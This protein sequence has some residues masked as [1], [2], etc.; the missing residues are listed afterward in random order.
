ME[1]QSPLERGFFREAEDGAP[2]F[3]PWGTAHRGHRLPGRD[4]K[5]RALRAVAL[6]FTSVA[7]VGAWTA[8][9][10]QPLLRSESPSGERIAGVLAL[11]GAVL[12]LALAAYA[13]W[14]VRFVESFP[15]IA[16][17]VSREERL[18]DAARAVP[19][20]KIFLVGLILAA[21]SGLVAWLRPQ[22]WWFAWLGIVLGVGL[23]V[24]SR[25]VARVAARDGREPI[26]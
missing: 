5:R 25:V 11:P 14:A 24:W 21:L 13:L 20:W 16:P 6:L 15:A 22:V 10:L 12:V 7:G 18:R 4:A 26:G 8:Q 3:F 9:A 1:Q 19:P 17:A 23:A 2:I